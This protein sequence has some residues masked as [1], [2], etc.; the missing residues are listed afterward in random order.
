MYSTTIQKCYLGLRS[1]RIGWPAVGLRF[2]EGSDVDHYFDV[3]L[4]A[5]A[6]SNGKFGV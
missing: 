6:S 5:A 4:E 2:K 1:C 3:L